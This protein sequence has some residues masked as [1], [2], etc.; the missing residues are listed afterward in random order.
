MSLRGRYLPEQ[1]E[2]FLAFKILDIENIFK[3]ISNNIILYKE[4]KCSS[5]CDFEII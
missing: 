1:N 3:R 4:R 5:E 2:L